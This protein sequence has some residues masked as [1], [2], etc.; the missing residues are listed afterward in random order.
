MFGVT[1][2]QKKQVLFFLKH[3][4]FLEQRSLGTLSPLHVYSKHSLIKF[5]S[6]LRATLIKANILIK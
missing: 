3:I 6:E 4:K 2:D 5:Q 1:K